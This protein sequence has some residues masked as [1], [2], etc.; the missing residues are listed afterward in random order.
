MVLSPIRIVLAVIGIAGGLVTL[1]VVLTV[2]AAFAGSPGECDSGERE[3]VINAS[4]AQQLQGKLDDMN[5]QLDG[6]QA[7]SFTFD[8]SE[9]TSRGVEFLDENN[10]PIDDLKVCFST[11]GPSASGT[12][13]AVLG[14]NVKVKVSGKVDLSGEHPRIEDLN[15]DV[16]S[17]PGFIT[18]G[19]EGMIKSVINDQM[20]KIDLEHDLTV[21]FGEGAATLSGQP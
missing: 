19:F 2:L 15:I 1:A 12:L 17:V 16:G 4:L 8:E 21:T 14:L 20:D 6:G 7:A 9:A 11:E 13:D 5:D 18:G 3:V 10:A